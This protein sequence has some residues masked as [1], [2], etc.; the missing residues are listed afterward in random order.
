MIDKRDYKAVQRLQHLNACI[1]ETLRLN[2]AV[3]SAGL[4]IAPRGGLII[5]GTLIPEGTTIV[6]PQYSLLRGKSPYECTGLPLDRWSRTS[7]KIGRVNHT[8]AGTDRR[9]FVK[10]DEWVPERFSTQPELVLDKSAFV[11]WSAGEYYG[12][13]TIFSCRRGR[14]AR[15]LTLTFISRTICVHWEEPKFDGNSRGRRSHTDNV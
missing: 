4:R 15:N 6:V 5:S 2:P 12:Y 1:Y 10:P 9:N 7:E 14:I 3:P 13:P 8:Y 11:P